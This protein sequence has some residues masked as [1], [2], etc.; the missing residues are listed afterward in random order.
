MGEKKKR[1]QSSQIYTKHNSQ[2]AWLSVEVEDKRKEG[3]IA[4]FLSAPA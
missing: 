3:E 2:N 4:I 1:N